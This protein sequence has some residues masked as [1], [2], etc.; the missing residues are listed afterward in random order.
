MSIQKISHKELLENGVQALPN[1]PSTPSLYSGH[2]MSARELKAA[3]DRLPTLIAERFNNLLYATGLFDENDPKDMLSELIATGIFPEHSLSQFFEDVESGA[4]ALYLKA[5]GKDSLADVI[6]ALREDL[7]RL[8]TYQF[9]TEGVGEY[10]SDV[11]I[12]PGGITFRREPT[13]DAVLEDDRHPVS[14]KAVHAALTPLSERVALL[15]EGARDILFDY[16]EISQS[17]SPSYA[18]KNVLEN[19]ALT[20]LGASIYAERNLFPEKILSLYRGDTLSITWDETTGSLVLNGSLPPSDT[21]TLLVPFRF[22]IT[23]D[24]ISA[25]ICYRDGS[26]HTE[27]GSEATLCLVA[28]GE[29]ALSLTLK[30]EDSIYNP[31]YISE[32]TV[33]L[34]YVGIKAESGITFDHYRINLVLQDYYLDFADYTPCIIA[35]RTPILP[36]R[37]AVKGPN[38]WQGDREMHGEGS[39]SIVLDPP[40]PKGTYCIS[41][42]LMSD[43]PHANGYARLEMENGTEMNRT[44]VKNQRTYINYNARS[45]IVAIRLY[46]ANS[47]NA[48]NSCFMSVRDFQIEVADQLR[49][50]YGAFGSPL[51]YEL[52]LPE[53]F[54]RY[55]DH[56][57]AFSEEEFN[58]FNFEERHFYQTVYRISLDGSFAF[59]AVPDAEGTF[60]A[61][62]TAP[63]ALV[64]QQLSS[65]RYR[66]RRIFLPRATV[67]PASADTEECV[68]FTKD[69]VFV[70]TRLFES[71]EELIAFLSHTPID[72]LY[73]DKPLISPLQMEGYTSPILLPMRPCADTAFY[74]ETGAMLHVSSTIQYQ[75]Y[76]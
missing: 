63:D 23:P 29:T 13:A 11:S 26:V 34:S 12:A 76:V 15:E 14:G 65:R 53:E 48:D 74:D 49:P 35:D 24:Y 72:I 42:C 8:D 73:V 1:R 57:L 68:W 21:P 16:P 67:L 37:L 59:S 7:A 52:S 61:P 18:R 9:K 25:C 4:L 75:T 41:F 40:L 36:S 17:Y 45:P 43:Y 66:P 32:D 69:T 71:A 6:T 56:F 31:L 3:F 64:W 33:F 46:A 27:D 28:D 60:S 51:S 38:I 10:L 44:A 58:Y 62:Y 20:R 55:Q 70:K 54:S 2:A 22:H 19:A 5:D 39:I 30:N 50:A 47:A